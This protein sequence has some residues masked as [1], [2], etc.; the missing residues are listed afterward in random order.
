MDIWFT[1]HCG[2]SSYEQQDSLLING[3]TYQSRN[4][5]ITLISAEGEQQLIGV[6]DGVSGSPSAAIAS[7]LI[8]ALL[9]E[10]CRNR[11]DLLDNGLV[12]VRLVRHA[13]DSYR[14]KL[15]RRKTYAA[16]TT[17]A[18]LHIRGNRAAMVNSG[19]SRVY[20]VRHRDGHKPDW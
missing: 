20:R 14:E 10:A 11:Q 12:G 9:Q 6:A 18:A 2:Q 15:A 1:Q 7:R 17:L 3:Q 16:A 13:C 5:A 8:L 4:L 19:D